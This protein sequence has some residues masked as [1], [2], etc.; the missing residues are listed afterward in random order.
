MEGKS[1]TGTDE[2]WTKE[3]HQFWNISKPSLI[4]ARPPLH[5]DLLLLPPSLHHLQIV[6]P[7]S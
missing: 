3:A 6:L 1:D 2:P 5:Q 7:D 4:V